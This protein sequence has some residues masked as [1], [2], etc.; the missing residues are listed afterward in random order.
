MKSLSDFLFLGSSS[1]IAACGDS[2][3]NKSVIFN[4]L[5]II[6]KNPNVHSVIFKNPKVHF[7]ILKN[8]NMHFRNLVIWDTLLP[9]KRNIVKGMYI[10]LTL[11]S[12]VYQVE[13]LCL[14][15]Y[16]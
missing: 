2:Q 15:L 1:L 6:L 3:D 10:I 5:S 16:E 9:T 7:I 11:R 13:T 12:P 14:A 8:S 4:V